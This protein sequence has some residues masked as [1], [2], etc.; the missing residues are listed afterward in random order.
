[1]IFVLNLSPLSITM[2]LVLLHSSIGG[3]FNG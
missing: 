2:W 1:M 3:K